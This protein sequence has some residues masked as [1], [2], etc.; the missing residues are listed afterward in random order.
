MSQQLTTVESELGDTKSAVS[1]NSQTIAKMNADGTTAYEAQWGVKASVGDI[2]AG[3]GLVA[4]K[5]PDGST[6]SQCTVLADQFSVGHVATDGSEETIY[7][8][9]VTKDGIYMDTAY[10][11][12]ATVQDLVAGDVVA[13]TVKATAEIV[14]PRIK[15]GTIE[16]GN[17]FAVD[18]NGNFNSNDATMNNLTADGGRFSNVTID[19]TCIV[20]KIYASH[21]Y[22]DIY[23]RHDW[24]IQVKQFGKLFNSSTPTFKEIWCTFFIEGVSGMLRS[25]EIDSFEISQGQYLLVLEDGVEIYREYLPTAPGASDDLSSPISVDMKVANDGQNVSYQ[26]AIEN[27]GSKIQPGFT[28]RT[29]IPIQNVRMAWSKKSKTVTNTSPH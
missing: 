17:R 2:Q 20:E 28:S 10:I 27:Q 8:F 29:I 11:K 23:S 13:D 19:D 16:I 21:I 5:N 15:G 6:T 14:A 1:T 26:I 24:E 12:A 4:K 25:L 7:P 3:I 18:E 22:G 9:I